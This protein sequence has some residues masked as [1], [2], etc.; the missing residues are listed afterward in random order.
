[1]FNSNPVRGAL[2]G[3]MDD[4]K[5]IIGLPED[6]KD[7]T[8]K[9][10]KKD[11]KAVAEAVSGS[12]DEVDAR[13]ASD[14]D[15]SMGE[16]VDDKHYASRLAPSGSDS[17]DEDDD[18]AP[19]RTAYELS[20]DISL[21]PTPSDSGSDSLLAT[22]QKTSKSKSKSK[23]ENQSAASDF[24][25]SLMGGY[26]S[27]SESEPEDDDVAAAGNVRR[28]RMGQQARRK[29]WEKK[30]GSG[31]NHVKTQ[32]SAPN[33]DSGW[34]MRRGATDGQD[35]RGAGR[36]G[37][38]GRG[39]SG[40][41][42]NPRERFQGSGDRPSRPAR[43]DRLARPAAGGRF[44]KPAADNKPIHPSWEAAKKAKEKKTNVAFEGK[45]V[46]FD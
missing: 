35:A 15:V 17:E 28:N 40:F 3:V 10:A 43:D 22:A 38:G 8:G 29:L 9:K 25:P 7:A 21:S 16:D 6:K 4:I 26:W 45:K 27:G 1:M 36:F 39:G 20:R 12:E 19:Q 13:V 37:R 34:D 33:R 46:T 18:G 11:K 24:L 32:I 2:P 14:S 5:R 31:A 30:F 41:G 44:S 23:P 42:N